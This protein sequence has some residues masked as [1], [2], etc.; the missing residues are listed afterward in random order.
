[1]HPSI[2]L[3]NEGSFLW[4]LLS[5][6]F[7]KHV[8]KGNLHGLKYESFGSDF[9]IEITPSKYMLVIFNWDKPGV[10]GMLGTLLGKENINIAGMSLGRRAPQDVA[11]TVLNVDSLVSQEILREIKNAP[12][13]ISVK[14]VKL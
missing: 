8:P 12:H 1:M 14:L 6:R 3:M 5:N 2:S 4:I 7:A 13:I 10:V 11:L 9:H